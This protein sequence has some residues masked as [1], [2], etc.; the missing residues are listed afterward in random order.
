MKHI[1][2]IKI[3]EEDEGVFLA[4]SEPSESH[5]QGDLGLP[6]IVAQATSV[7][8]AIDAYAALYASMEDS[9]IP[10]LGEEEG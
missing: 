9:T 8:D 1:L 4:F 7:V 2:T 5:V 3:V 10:A 6:G